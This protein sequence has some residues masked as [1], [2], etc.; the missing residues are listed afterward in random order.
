MM[1]D[2]TNLALFVTAAWALILLPGPDMLYVLTRGIAQ[3]RRAGLLSAVGVTLGILVHTLAAALGL[4]VILQT[5]ALAFLL[6]KYLGA[7]YLIYLGVQTFRAPGAM[8]LNPAPKPAA[9]SAIFWQGVLSNVLNPKIALFFLAFLPQFINAEY[10]DP[11]RQMMVLGLIFATF[12]LL[13]LGALGLFS[14]EV[15]AWLARRPDLSGKLRWVTGGTLIGLGIRLG[16]PDQ[17]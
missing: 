9:A 16:L 4:A 15:G 11:R 10:G 5:S 6:V 12:G 3:G 17:R 7:A 13:F 2:T 1:L 14:G 8:T